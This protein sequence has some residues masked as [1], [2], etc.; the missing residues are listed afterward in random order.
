MRVAG[1]RCRS[2]VALRKLIG[3][4]LRGICIATAGRLTTMWNCPSARCA[5]P[6]WFSRPHMPRNE[7][8][9]GCVGRCDCRLDR[10]KND[11]AKLGPLSEAVKF[12]VRNR[13][14]G[15]FQPW[16]RQ[17][18]FTMSLCFPVLTF[19]TQILVPITLIC[20]LMKVGAPTPSSG[21]PV[22][23][24]SG[25]IVSQPGPATLAKVAPDGFNCLE[26]V[27]FGGHVRMFHWIADVQF[28]RRH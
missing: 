14:P 13:G 28:P 3:P 4:T 22:K 19:S 11:Q 5:G 16:V 2:L 17:K 8:A 15:Q 9:V 1:P 24:P 7:R 23:P 27:S 25:L 21:L 26:T 10:G 20:S 18:Q 12:R 6:M